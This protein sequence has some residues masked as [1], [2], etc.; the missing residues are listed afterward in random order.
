MLKVQLHLVTNIAATTL[1]GTK[2]N[3]TLK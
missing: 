1:E 3:K 2:G